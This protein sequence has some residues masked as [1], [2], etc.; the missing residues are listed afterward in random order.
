ML[1]FAGGQG[2][3]GESKRRNHCRCCAKFE[4]KLK[5]KVDFSFD[6]PLFPISLSRSNK[7]MLFKRLFITQPA[8][9]AIPTINSFRYDFLTCTSPCPCHYPCT[10]II[11]IK[12]EKKILRWLSF[13][14]SFSFAF[15]LAKHTQRGTRRCSKCS[16]FF[17]ISQWPPYL[18]FINMV[19]ILRHLSHLLLLIPLPLL[20]DGLLKICEFAL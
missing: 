10:R 4:A 6:F 14:R 20:H 15:H 2:V 3:E 19:A 5:L 13:S 16:A 7:L 12:K 18:L 17:I 1:I 9:F 8:L 11:H